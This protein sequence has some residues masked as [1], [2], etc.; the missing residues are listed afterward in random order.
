[1]PKG[2]SSARMRNEIRKTAAPNSAKV[3]KLSLPSADFRF[4]ACLCRPPGGTMVAVNHHQGLYGQPLR[5]GD[6]RLRPWLQ[7]AAGP[8][9][10]L[11]EV[12]PDGQPPAMALP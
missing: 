2:C 10:H 8:C 3:R 6:A 11:S 4:I 1:M 5:R 12:I 9:L 7:D